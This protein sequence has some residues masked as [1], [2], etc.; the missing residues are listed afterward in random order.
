[1]H[2]FKTP[3]KPVYFRCKICI[4]EMSVIFPVKTTEIWVFVNFKGLNSQNDLMKTKLK[5]QTKEIAEDFL[6]MNF[7]FMIKKLNSFLI[8]YGKMPL[9]F[10]DAR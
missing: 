4:A 8:S 6:D 3:N 2:L 7:T 9:E 1:M 10:L 5:C